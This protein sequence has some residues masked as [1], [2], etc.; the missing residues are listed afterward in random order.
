MSDNYNVRYEELM[1]DGTWVD[2]TVG[3]MTEQ[4]ARGYYES[5]L[6]R[7]DARRLRLMRSSDEVLDERE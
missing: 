5:W 1:G 6:S 3:P 2:V 4:R 7:D